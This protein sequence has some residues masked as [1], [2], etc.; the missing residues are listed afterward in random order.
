MQAVLLVNSKMCPLK[1]TDISFLHSLASSGWSLSK[2]TT[3]EHLRQHLGWSYRLRRREQY[4]REDTKWVCWTIVGS[5]S[6]YFRFSN[7]K[8]QL[9]KISFSW[10]NR[11]CLI[12]EACNGAPIVNSLAWQ[13]IPSILCSKTSQLLCQEYGSPKFLGCPCG[14]WGS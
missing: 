11:K 10:W 1:E 12:L 6:T 5:C 13:I 14:S 9:S 8:N 2:V 3:I 7:L 4:D